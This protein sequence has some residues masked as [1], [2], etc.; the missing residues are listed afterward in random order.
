MYNFVEKYIR[1]G[2][3][4]I[5]HR[6]SVANNKYMKN[7]DPSQPSKYIMYYDANNLYGWAMV[8]LLCDGGYKWEDVNNW[9]EEKIMN[10]G[11]NETRG[12]I[13]EVDLEYPESLHDLHNGYPLAPEKK[14]IKNDMLSP[15][16][17]SLMKKLDISNDSVE[18]T[19]NRFNK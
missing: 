18:K 2:M 19:N 4:F 11:V 13:F 14:I 10:I 17:K 1:G 16:Q 5:S 7:Y 12:Y 3:S 15:F 9:N 8:Q 6:H